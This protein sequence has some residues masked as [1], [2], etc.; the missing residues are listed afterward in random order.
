MNTVSIPSAYIREMQTIKK[1]ISS[2]PGYEAIAS[3]L[4]EFVNQNIVAGLIGCIVPESG[5][6]HRIL[7]VKEYNGRGASGTS[8]WNCGE[9]LI[10]WTYWKNKRPLIAKYNADS[11]STQKLP[12][13]WAT[14]SQGAPVKE[15]GSLVAVS[16]GKH[17]AGLSLKNQMLFLVIYYQDLIKKLANETNIAVIVAKIYQQKAGNGY[18]SNIS[19]PVTRAYV[20][21]KNKYSSSSGNHYLQSLKIAQEY[22]GSPI[23]PSSVTVND[24]LSMSSTDSPNQPRPI[25]ASRGAN[26]VY[27]LSDSSNDK[28]KRVSDKRKE[29]F[30]NMINGFSENAPEL[31]RTIILS[32]EM[33]GSEIL[34]EGQKPKINGN[35]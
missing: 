7:N 14:Y 22:L 16:D 5:T 33:Y 25:M 17:I 28:N 2:Y 18:Y 3:C 6:N 26:T 13:D 27:R 23:E 20:T 4:G 31:G 15:N 29:N 1:S 32:S 12:I 8:G 24:G 19:D 35:S 9:G 10:Q 11:R 34:K 30:A 21:A